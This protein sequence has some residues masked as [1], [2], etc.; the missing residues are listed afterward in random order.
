MIFLGVYFL[1]KWLPI[2]IS[3][4]LKNMDLTRTRWSLGFELSDFQHRKANLNIV[5]SK[6]C[7]IF[8][9]H[10]CKS[11]SVQ[12]VTSNFFP[13]KKD[14]VRVTFITNSRNYTG[15]WLGSWFSFVDSLSVRMN[16][17]I[18]QTHSFWMDW[19]TSQLDWRSIRHG[20]NNAHICKVIC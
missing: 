8:S 13:M 14:L 19:P 7:W 18:G 10:V 11:A 16:T 20:S 1:A 17:F 6:G 3:L 2:R 15:T 5:R 9:H 4:N 12:L